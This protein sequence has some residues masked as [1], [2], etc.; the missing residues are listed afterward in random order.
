MSPCVGLMYPS[1][2][3][4]S[5]ERRRRDL[6]RLRSRLPGIDVV[7]CFDR[8]LASIGADDPDDIAAIDVAVVLG[9]PA[10]LVGR[11]PRLAWVQSVTTGIDHVDVG[12]LAVAGVRLTTAGGT[13]SPE[14]AEFVVARVLE[15]WK[16]L[17][18][19]A[20]AQRLRRWEPLYGRALSGSHVL[21]VGFGAINQAVAGLLAPFEVELKVVRRSLQATAASSP[22]VIT[23]ADLDAGLRWADA[24]VVALPA[25]TETDDMFDAARFAQFRPGAFFCNVG[26]GTT[27]VESALIAALASGRVGG[28]ALDVAVI[29]PLPPSDPLWSSDARISPH[30]SSAPEM[31]ISRVLDLLIENMEQFVSGD[32]MRNEVE[33]G[34]SDDTTS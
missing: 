22:E 23:F 6:D 20:D 2:I 19:I 32:R 25:T 27:V 26:R 3:H 11:M 12:R 18:E 21:L 10:D 5:A 33:L 29:E 14:I 7:E 28:A 4:G 30:C 17:P 13:S 8:D 9:D 1:S 34:A 15:H 31:A 16:R 24:V